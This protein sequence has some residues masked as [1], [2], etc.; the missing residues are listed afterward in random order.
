MPDSDR[1]E[2]SAWVVR[3][4]FVLYTARLSGQDVGLCHRYREEEKFETNA[5]G[6]L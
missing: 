2:V 3:C 1:W 5:R 4:S 6:V